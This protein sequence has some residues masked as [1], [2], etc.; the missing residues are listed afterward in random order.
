MY[1][2]YFD[3]AD[4]TSKNNFTVCGL[5]AI[6]VEHAA[7][8]SRQIEKIRIVGEFKPE[9]LLKFST[10]SRPVYCSEDNHRQTKD[11][12]ISAAVDHGVVFF[13]Y[14]HFN[15]DHVAHDSDRNRIY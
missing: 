15:E 6:H 14:C 5:T 12:V 9:D 11:S 4:H 10:N 13:G 1:L 3:E 2:G 7:D 8:L